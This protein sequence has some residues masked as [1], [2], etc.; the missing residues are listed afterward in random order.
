LAEKR[1]YKPG[2]NMIY[3]YQEGGICPSHGNPN[4]AGS[5]GHASKLSEKTALF[6]KKTTAKDAG[7]CLAA[8]LWLNVSSKI[9]GNAPGI[10]IKESCLCN[11][12]LTLS[13]KK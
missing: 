11:F 6:I 10:L 4:I 1:L 8:R 5:F 3:F 7:C 12:L 13:N 2:N 9:A